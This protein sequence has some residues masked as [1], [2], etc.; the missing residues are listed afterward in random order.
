M[1]IPTTGG[2]RATNAGI[3]ANRLIY[4]RA[5]GRLATGRGGGSSSLVGS[6]AQFFGR[7]P[8][9]G[10]P[11]VLTS[12]CCPGD[13]DVFEIR[14]SNPDALP[15]QLLTTTNAAL[16]LSQWDLLPPS[17]LDIFLFDVEHRYFFDT[18][19]TGMRR[20]FKLSLP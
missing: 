7:R 6:I 13:E 19:A 11:I 5:R 10:P 14:F 4:V 15:Y 16:P 1:G 3:P 9:S 12:A 18:N 17:W 2:W 8:T 20:F